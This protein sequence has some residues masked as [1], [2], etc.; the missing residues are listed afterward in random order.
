MFEM[1][2]GGRGGFQE[3][4]P[5]V[6]YGGAGLRLPLAIPSYHASCVGL[7]Y[8]PSCPVLVV[9]VAVMISY[10]YAISYFCGFTS[11]GVWRLL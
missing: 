9:V 4:T 11:A 1:R 7:Q 2:R 8:G 5:V 10:A 6:A 3:G